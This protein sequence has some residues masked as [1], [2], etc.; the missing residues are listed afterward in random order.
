[1]FEIYSS[2]YAISDGPGAGDDGRL[3]LPA[4]EA[5]QI[6]YAASDPTFKK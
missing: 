6:K 1:V 5:L 4:I 2:S 3:L